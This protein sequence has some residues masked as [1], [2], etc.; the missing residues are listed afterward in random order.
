MHVMSAHIMAVFTKH[1]CLWT[2]RPTLQIHF[3]FQSNLHKHRHHHIFITGTVINTAAHGRGGA[4]GL[5]ACQQDSCDVFHLLRTLI[6]L[7]WF[8]GCEWGWHILTPKTFVWEWAAG[9]AKS[10]QSVVKQSFCFHPPHI[11]LSGCRWLDAAKQFKNLRL[12]WK[13]SVF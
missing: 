7:Q 9:Q 11:D 10:C 8:I 1:I 5:K 12:G 6:F 2:Q 4:A 3:C 13:I